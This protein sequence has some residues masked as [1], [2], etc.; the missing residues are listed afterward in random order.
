MSSDATAELERLTNAFV[1]EFAK[2]K[3]TLETLDHLRREVLAAQDA[4]IS[5]LTA[6]NHNMGQELTAQDMTIKALK[7]EIGSLRGKL[8]QEMELLGAAEAESHRL[9][10]R[11]SVDTPIK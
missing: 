6:D 1:A 4:T 10:G 8:H 7:A 9:S 11:M 2:V 3:R 5:R